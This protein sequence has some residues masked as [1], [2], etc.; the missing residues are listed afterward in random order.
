MLAATSLD[1]GA[2]YVADT[3]P[4]FG[5]GSADA[6]RLYAA[7]GSTLLDSYS[8]TAH[9]TSTYG[10]CPDGTGTFGE[11]TSSRGAANSC[12]VA[13]PLKVN[14]AESGGD[15]TDWIELA[16]PTGSAYDASGMVLGDDTD[17]DDANHA[18][19]LPAGTS[20]PAHGY[21]AVDVPFGLGS[22]DQARLFAVGGVTLVDST[23]WA[24]HATPTWGR[25][26]DMTGSFTNTQLST[27]GGKNVCPGDIV[28][29][30]WPGGSAV[31]TV[32]ETGLAT[33]NVSGLYYQGSG[34]ATPGT[35]WA[36]RNGS[37]ERDVQAGEERQQLGGRRWRLG[38][39]QAA[40]LPGRHRE[41]RR[42]GHHLHRRRHRRRGLCLHRA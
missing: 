17:G 20:V 35:L 15:A 28:A 2:Y 26:P 29:D 27:K 4:G 31:T 40:A 37:P 39:R 11:T 38:R 12:V 21:L 32:D 3:E 30:P 42:R 7:D 9:A 24:V 18:L 10:R 5:L 8:W 6:A 14:E 22:A 41:P 16:N 23:S 19:T 1:A 25:C 34:S 13:N 33:S 36:V